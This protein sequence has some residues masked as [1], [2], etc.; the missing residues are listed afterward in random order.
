MYKIKIESKKER[1]KKETNKE[2]KKEGKMRLKLKNNDMRRSSLFRIL[3]K[4]KGNI[5]RKM[6]M[7]RII[8]GSDVGNDIPTK[9]IKVGLLRSRV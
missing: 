2:T 4:K 9:R 1:K 7:N 6:K 8:S 3:L 5:N